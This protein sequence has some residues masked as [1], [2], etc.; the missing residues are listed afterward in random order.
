MKTA[1]SFSRQEM[2]RK[3][4][5][6]RFYFTYL[7]ATG[8]ATPYRRIKSVR[9]I[10]GIVVHQ[11]IAKICNA[12][13][14]GSR[15]SD[16]TQAPEQALHR[17]DEIIAG[18]R[19]PASA[20]FQIA[21]FVNDVDVEEEIAHWQTLVPRCVENGCRVMM[22]LNVR[23]NSANHTIQV[24]H[25]VS[26]HARGRQHRGIIDLLIRDRESILIIDWK[27]HSIENTDLRQV[28]MYQR[29]IHELERIPTS[30]L[31]GIVVDLIR[32]E[33]VESHYRPERHL[34]NPPRPTSIQKELARDRDP[35][36]ARPSEENCARCP[37]TAICCDS[38]IK[39]SRLNAAHPEKSI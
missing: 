30:R 22:S 23:A 10:G 12:V 37:F 17:F 8:I 27:C 19:R 25:E 26:L 31:S 34:L 5:P 36:P 28:Q 4:C 15:V 35:Y 33:L 14:E 16:F 9:E 11:A 6:K 38:M 39:P 24:E 29:Y 20:E 3:K 7:D 2:G 32:E 1:T 21:E 13:A 18:A